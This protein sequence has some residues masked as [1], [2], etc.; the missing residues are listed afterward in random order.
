METNNNMKKT[1]LIIG[2]GI[3][4]LVCGAILAKEGYSVRILEKHT[5][6]GGGL[7]TFKRNGVDFET[8]IHVISGFQDNGVLRRL[9]HISALPVNCASNQPTMTVS[10]TFR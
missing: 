3:G 4:G 5:M 2:G 9:L 6:A 7:H 8:G 1:V 10:T